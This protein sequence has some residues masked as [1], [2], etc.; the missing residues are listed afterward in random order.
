MRSADCKWTDAYV[1]LKVAVRLG[2]EEGQGGERS[3]RRVREVTGAGGGGAE[4]RGP[5][6][7]HPS[8][9]SSGSTKALRPDV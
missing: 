8:A 6:V 2:G 4:T 5:G 1:T 9:E 3:C 7:G